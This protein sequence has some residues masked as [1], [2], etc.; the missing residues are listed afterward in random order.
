VEQLTADS[1]DPRLVEAVNPAASAEPT[2]RRDP[3]A[4]TVES[5]EYTH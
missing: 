1:G 3:V 5:D 2:I 4:T